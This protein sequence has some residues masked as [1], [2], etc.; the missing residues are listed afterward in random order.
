M[1]SAY[2]EIAE[3]Q[4][5]NKKPMYMKDWVS[6]L[7]DFLRMTGSEVLVNAGKISREQALEKAR[8]EF[9]RFRENNQDE[10]SGVE[11]DF[12]KQLELTEKQ[13]RSFK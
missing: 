8:I 4:A 12:M 13:L 9:D 11:R 6:R 3:L 10:L 7:D 2:L 5:L 1:V